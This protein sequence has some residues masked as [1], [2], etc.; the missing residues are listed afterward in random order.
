MHE[1]YDRDDIY[2]MVEDEFQAVAQSFTKLLHHAEYMRMKKKA[3]ENPPNTETKVTDQVSTEIKRK[4]RARA[5]HGKQVGAVKTMTGEVVSGSEED[6]KDDD[7]W[8]G[9]T[10][11]GLMTTDGSKQRTALLGLEKIPSSTR[12]AQGFGRGES[13]SPGKRRGKK[14]VLDIYGIGEKEHAQGID[15]HEEAPE[16]DGG[17]LNIDAAASS[18]LPDGKAGINESRS[19]SF[20]KASSPIEF[21]AAKGKLRKFSTANKPSIPG[22]SSTV[23]FT[24]RFNG[25]A[26]DLFDDGFNQPKPPLSPSSIGA[27]KDTRRRGRSIDRDKDKRS[28][29]NEIPTFLVR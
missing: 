9:T 19:S 6:V 17:C 14:G 2:I 11:A 4:L 15:E 23:K 3:R 21:P 24:S 10:L 13:D 29:Q 20:R 16:D 25:K 5:L 26:I 18:R 8:V 12:A 28:R 7:P 27:R 1:G 22:S